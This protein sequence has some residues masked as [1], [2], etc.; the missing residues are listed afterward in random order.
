MTLLITDRWRS[1]NI[2]KGHLTSQKGHQQNCQGDVWWYLF[3]FFGSKNRTILNLVAWHES[4]GNGAP[5]HIRLHLLSPSA[6]C[7]ASPKHAARKEA[8]S[9][10]CYQTGLL[11]NCWWCP[12][13][14]A[15]ISCFDILNF[16]NRFLFLGGIPCLP[17]DIQPYRNWGDR[18]FGFFFFGGGPN[19]P[20]HQVPGCPRYEQVHKKC[21][22]CFFVF[23]GGFFHSE[24][25][26]FI[27]QVSHEKTLLPSIILDG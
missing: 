1:L 6:G 14:L 11:R 26:F 17:I 8:F 20:A 16:H 18:C 25:G 2:W 22:L 9:W 21:S 12:R 27:Q 13:C 19:I 3:N 4:N 24:R 7:R 23:S 5:R 15:A 10:K